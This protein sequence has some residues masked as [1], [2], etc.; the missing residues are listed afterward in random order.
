MVTAGEDGSAFVSTLVEGVKPIPLRVKGDAYKLTNARFS[1][2]GTMVVIASRGCTAHICD[3]RGGEEIANLKHTDTVWDAAFS[4]DSKLIVTASGDESARVWEARSGLQL[5]Q[6]REHTGDI[7]SAAFSPNGKF[8]VTA[9]A[10][11]TARIWKV[12]DW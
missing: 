4:P 3:A 6:L 7:N 1:P 2:D 5:A 10:D 11:H 12:G 9:G 8:I